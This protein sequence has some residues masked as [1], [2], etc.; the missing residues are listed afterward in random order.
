MMMIV[1]NRTTEHG[2]AVIRSTEIMFH[3]PPETIKST[4]VNFQP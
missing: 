4:P 1:V 2:H 3:L